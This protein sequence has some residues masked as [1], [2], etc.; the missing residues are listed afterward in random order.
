MKRRLFTRF[1][2]GFVSFILLI[3]TVFNCTTIAWAFDYGKDYNRES[4]K[5]TYDRTTY[6]DHVDIRVVG[7]LT[8]DGT[9]QKV[10]I[11][12]VELKVVEPEQATLNDNPTT[13]EQNEPVIPNEK[14]SEAESDDSNILDTEEIN[15]PTGNDPRVPIFVVL[16]AIGSVVVGAIAAIKRK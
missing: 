2:S 8:L 13:P 5:A 7:D 14:T 12:N 3:G 4:A 6:F 16:L 10:T 1:V 15:P 11:Q 9:T